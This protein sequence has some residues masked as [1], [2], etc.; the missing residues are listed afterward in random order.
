MTNLLLITLRKHG[1]LPSKELW[2]T[3]NSDHETDVGFH[4][5]MARCGTLAREGI[6]VKE[7]HGANGWKYSLPTRDG[8]KWRPHVGTSN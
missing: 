8:N 2:R 7:R 4:V 3:F 6:L 5:L 1:P